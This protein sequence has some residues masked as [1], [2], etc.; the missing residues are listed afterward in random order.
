MYRALALLALCSCHRAIEDHGR[1]IEP[2]TPAVIAEPPS[3]SPCF[4]YVPREL[5]KHAGECFTSAE[6]ACGSECAGVHI[7]G[8][9]DEDA[10]DNA[11]AHPHAFGGHVVPIRAPGQVGG[12]LVSCHGW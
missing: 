6:L 5:G 8:P 3:P 2:P 10:R 1:E 4:R 7:C 9:I 12:Q 11:L